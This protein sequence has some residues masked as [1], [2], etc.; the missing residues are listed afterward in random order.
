MKQCWARKGFEDFLYFMK[1]SLPYAHS[2]RSFRTTVKL[3]LYKGRYEKQ[4][5]LIKKGIA[6]GAKLLAGKIKK[7]TDETI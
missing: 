6:Q 7:N 3:F 1:L 4:V 2:Y 5:S